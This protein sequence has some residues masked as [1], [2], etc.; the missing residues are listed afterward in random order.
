MDF[1]GF[2]KVLWRKE[3]LK[4]KILTEAQKILW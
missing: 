3:G 2:E 4:S 1:S